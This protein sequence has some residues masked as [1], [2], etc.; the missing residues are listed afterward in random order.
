MSDPLKITVRE[1]LEEMRSNQLMPLGI[2]SFDM[3]KEE[4]ILSLFF[5][6]DR[7]ET[8]AL[9]AKAGLRGQF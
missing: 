5:G 3:K 2:L 8:N 7:D 1:A 4:L 9:L 6:V